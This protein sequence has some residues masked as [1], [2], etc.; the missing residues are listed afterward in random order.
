ML[1]KLAGGM[2]QSTYLYKVRLLYIVDTIVFIRFNPRTYIRY[3]V[4]TVIFTF[5]FLCFN[6]RTYI[7]YDYGWR[8][9]IFFGRFQSTYLY[10]V[11]RDALKGVNYTPLFQSTY[12]YKVR[13]GF[14]IDKL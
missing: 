14:E 9:Y 10:K 2:F 8:T 5:D 6:P 3:D 13:P 7:R 11:R 1:A 12:L 4:P